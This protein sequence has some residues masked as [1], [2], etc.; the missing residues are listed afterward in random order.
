MLS[1][2]TMGQLVKFT[3]EE[4]E[5]LLPRGNPDSTNGGSLYEELALFSHQLRAVLGL[6]K[7]LW[8]CQLFLLIFQKL[9]KCERTLKLNSHLLKF[10]VDL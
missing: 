6:A 1:D 3:H 8:L 9:R 2:K 4:L 5:P 10:F 7:L